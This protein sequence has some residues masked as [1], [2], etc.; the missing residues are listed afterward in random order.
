MADKIYP[1]NGSLER[2]IQQLYIVKYKFLF[3]VIFVIVGSIICYL[4]KH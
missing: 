1:P 3:G 4:I 2:I